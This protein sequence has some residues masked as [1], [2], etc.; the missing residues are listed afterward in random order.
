MFDIDDVVDQHIVLSVGQEFINVNQFGEVLMEYEIQEG[1]QVLKK[2]NDKNRVTGIYSGRGCPWRIHA[3]PNS[4]G[5]TFVIKT[6]NPNHTC[7]RFSIKKDGVTAAWIAKKLASNVRADPH[8]NINV[9][10]DYL[11]EKY[12]VKAN[13]TKLYKAKCIVNEE[14]D[15][16]H[17]RAYKKLENYGLTVK[18]KNPGTEFVIQYQNANRYGQEKHGVILVNPQFM[19][20]FICFDAYKQGFLKGSITIDGNNEI[21]PL[22]Y[23]V[24]ETEC[25]DSWLFF[26]HQLLGCTGTVIPT[27]EPF[28]F[29]T[30]KQKGPIEAIGIKFPVAHHRHCSRHLYNNFKTEFGGG[31]ALRGYFWRPSKSYN[32]TGFQRAIN[33]MKE[34]KLEAYEWLMKT[35]ICMWARHAFDHRVKSDHIANNMIESF[36]QMKKK[37][38]VL[39]KDIRYCHPVYAGADEFEVQDGLNSY[40]VNLRNKSCECGVW[41]ATRLPCK[42]VGLTSNWTRV[43]VLDYCH[44][45][46]NTK[47]NLMANGEMIHPLSDVKHLPDTALLPPILKRSI[48]RLS[49]NRKREADE[50]PK[51]DNKRKSSSIRCDRCK[52]YGHNRRTCKGGPIKGKRKG[53]SSSRS[54]GVKR[55]SMAEEPTLSLSEGYKVFSKFNYNL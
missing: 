3:S 36:N 13:K 43:G 15:G 30:D 11:A 9:M 19:R 39:Q 2:K 49:K 34:E 54:S 45:Y 52:E 28:T 10:E 47:R 1:I 22:A 8:M 46:L 21:F 4:D 23:D 31:P 18:E 24:S 7:Q 48:G 16:S 14:T 20:L 27:R 53:T 29:M 42:H 51:Q 33:A 6:L 50:P 55:K 37:L 35:L 44:S 38:D 5:T 25:K 41:V 32:A 26:L 12:G 17:T 40:V